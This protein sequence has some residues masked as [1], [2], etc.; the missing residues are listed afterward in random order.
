MGLALVRERQQ[1]ADAVLNTR[2]PGHAQAGRGK[3]DA[4]LIRIELGIALFALV[5]V[6]GPRVWTFALGPHTGAGLDLAAHERHAD[7]IDDLEP[8]AVQA[9]GQRRLGAIRDAAGATLDRI[10]PGLACGPAQGMAE[11][12]AQAKQAGAC[13][14]RD[15]CHGHCPASPQGQQGATLAQGV[16]VFQEEIGLHGRI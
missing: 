8:P 15:A 13:H 16:G 3:H 11:G 7:V 9:Q 4:P 12:R 5:V 14:A 6:E 10:G 2:H 1:Q